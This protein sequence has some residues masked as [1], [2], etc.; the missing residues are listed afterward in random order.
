MV[1]VYRRHHEEVQ[2][3]DVSPYHVLSLHSCWTLGCVST[4]F[5]VFFFLNTMFLLSHTPFGFTAVCDINK[6]VIIGCRYFIAVEDEKITPL[7]S[8]YK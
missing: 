6:M 1:F 5:Y 2:S 7:S 8:E 3:L 4:L